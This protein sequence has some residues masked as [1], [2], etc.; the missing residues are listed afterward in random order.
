MTRDDQRIAWLVAALV[1]AGAVVSWV[2]FCRP[3][4]P[5]AELAKTTREAVGLARDA[6][7]SVESAA[8]W[9][10]RFTL[11]AVALGVSVPLIAAVYIWR[12]SA[13]GPLDAAELLDGI[14]RHVL[15]LD[16]RGRLP[17]GSA[18]DPAEAGGR[19]QAGDP[20]ALPSV[21][22]HTAFAGDGGCPTESHGDPERP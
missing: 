7:S 12:W 18:V 1:L 21:T 8:L 4:D 9:R 22:R 11:L 13:G 16:G 10:G 14:E 15:G 17:D 2:G 6:Q 20:E 3:I 19:Q 5:N